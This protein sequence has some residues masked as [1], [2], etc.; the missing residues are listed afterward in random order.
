MKLRGTFESLRVRSS[1]A[2]M[3]AMETERRL[4]ENKSR[5]KEKETQAHQLQERVDLTRQYIALLKELHVAQ[6]KISSNEAKI[7]LVTEK[8]DRLGG[9]VVQLEQEIDK[10]ET[11]NETARKKYRELTEELESLQI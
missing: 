5:F 10:L 7:R 11:D 6:E 9:K 2:T 3:K 4:E 8:A 1:Q